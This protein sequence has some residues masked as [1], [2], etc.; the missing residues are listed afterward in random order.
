MIS[1][2]IA[3]PLSTAPPKLSQLLALSYHLR[4]SLSSSRRRFLRSVSSSS[5]LHSL[6]KPTTMFG[7][8][9]RLAD[10]TVSQTP[11][12]YIWVTFNQNIRFLCV[13]QNANWEQGRFY[14]SLH[15][16]C[17]LLPLRSTALP[18]SSSK[19]FCSVSFC[20]LL[21]Y[22]TKIPICTYTSGLSAR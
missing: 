18:S 20:F 4:Y 14:P 21:F 10:V 8:A 12:S 5:R 16:D 2:A 19:L 1:C 3:L 15:P 11:S 17:S 13:P 7:I 9:T 22:Q 6:S